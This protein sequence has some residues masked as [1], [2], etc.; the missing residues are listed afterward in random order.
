M[1]AGGMERKYRGRMKCAGRMEGK[2]RYTML[3]AVDQ[4]DRTTTGD[5]GR[6]EGKYGNTMV[7][8]VKRSTN[9]E[10]G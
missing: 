8:T 4:K 3:Y 6:I 1:W 9:M 7:C 5:R 10:V 2:G